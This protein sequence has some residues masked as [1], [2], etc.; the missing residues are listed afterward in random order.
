MVTGAS[1]ADLAVV[2]VDAR[3]GVLEQSRRHAYLSAQLGIKH[4]V[5][6]VNKMDLVDW[7]RG[8]L[9]RDRDASSRPCSRSSASPTRWRSRCPR[10]TATTWSIARARAPWYDGPPLLR[11]LEQRRGRARPQ[12]RRRPV[13]RPVGR[14]HHRLPRLR[15][16]DGQRHAAARRRRR[17][18][19][20]RR[21]HDGRPD[22]DARRAGGGRVPADVGRRP[23][24]RRP[25]RRARQH[26]LRRRRPAAGGAPARR[27]GLL[28][29]RHA[30]APRRPLP[31]QAQHPPR[32]GGRRVDRRARRPRDA[33]RRRPGRASSS[34]TTSRACTSTSPR[35]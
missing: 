34:S 15:G 5:A 7:D 32:A 23:P 4:M 10:C 31:A 13:P 12:P 3:N 16:A 30:A 24:G 18:A 33:A 11:H 26:D 35:R 6:C 2:L 28:D 14:A 17:R 19:P 27:A 22:R 21:P 29:V 8:A 25:R 20:A 9:P 1:T